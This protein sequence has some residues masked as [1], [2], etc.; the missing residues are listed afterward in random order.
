MRLCDCLVS[1]VAWISFWPLGHSLQSQLSP[2]PCVFFSGFFLF[3]VGCNTCSQLIIHK[4]TMQLKA[5]G[6]PTTVRKRLLLLTVLGR[7]SHRNWISQE[8]CSHFRLGA[9]H[10]KTRIH[11]SETIVPHKTSFLGRPMLFS[12]QCGHDFYISSCI[13]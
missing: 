10:S 3:P 7:S 12:Q 2:L 6:L 1:R 13:S 8:S 9:P 11:L 4:A 5:T